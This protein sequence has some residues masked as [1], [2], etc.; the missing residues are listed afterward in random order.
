MSKGIVLVA[1]LSAGGFAAWRYIER[2]KLAEALEAEPVLL[3]LRAVLVA[4]KPE[5]LSKDVLWLYAGEFKEKAAEMLPWASLT[6]A[7]D[8]LAALPEQLAPYL[9]PETIDKGIDTIRQNLSP[10]GI[11]L[12]TS[13]D[14]AVRQLRRFTKKESIQQRQENKNGGLRA[15]KK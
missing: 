10:L 14:T 9:T 4:K 15:N 6:T 8:A 11:Q 5:E 2:K 12:S 7:E 1:G 3:A 13:T